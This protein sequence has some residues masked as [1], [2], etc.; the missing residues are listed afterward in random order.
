MTPD[1]SPGATFSRF[2]LLLAAALLAAAALSP[3]AFR[4]L[5]PLGPYPIHRIFNRTGMLVFLGGTFLL[6]R[7]LRLAD[8]EGLGYGAPAAVLVRAALVAFLAG[9]AVMG[10]T[11]IAL[12]A[13]GPCM[14][15]RLARYSGCCPP[16][17][18]PVLPSD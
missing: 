14:R 4:M 9:V 7:R 17:R 13:L 8:R 3:L 2:V 10:L 5:E 16:R 11:S 12:F 6:L 1:Q 15:T 18:S